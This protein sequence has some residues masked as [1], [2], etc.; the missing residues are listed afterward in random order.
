MNTGN[1]SKMLI[2]T[3]IAVVS[4]GASGAYASE[5]TG[6]VS[7]SSAA[8]TG[9]S[10]S[11]TSGSVSGGSTGS[12]VSGTVSGG[13]GSTVSGFVSGGGG[14]G[15]GN[16]LGGNVSSPPPVT[17][18]DPRGAVLAQTPTYA[19]PSLG[20]PNTGFGPGPEDTPSLSV[21]MTTLLAL[22]LAYFGLLDRY[23]FK[24]T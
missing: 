24:R 12:S 11:Q 3:L 6:T 19:S 20:L 8:N 7:S 23:L 18:S 5:V 15:G 21:A 13:S 2:A 22:T 9:G 16:S 4:L 1:T 14:G 17:F 10:G